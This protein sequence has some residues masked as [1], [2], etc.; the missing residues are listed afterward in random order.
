MVLGGARFLLA[1]IALKPATLL[2]DARLV[3]GQQRAIEAVMDAPPPT[4]SPAA[5]GGP[6]GYDDRSTPPAPPARAFRSSQ[7]TDGVR[8]GSPGTGRRASTTHDRPAPGHAPEQE[9]DRRGHHQNSCTAVLKG[10]TGPAGRFFARVAGIAS[11]S[12]GARAAWAE[13]SVLGE[14]QSGARAANGSSALLSEP[15]LT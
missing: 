6:S 14:P 10:V 13:S 7:S 9:R 15:R 1:R 12:L 8:R 2:V 5:H 11:P 4:R 3:V